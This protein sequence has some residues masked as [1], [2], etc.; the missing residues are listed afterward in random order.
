MLYFTFTNIVDKDN[1]FVEDD[2]FMK[3]VEDLK[4]LVEPTLKNKGF[5][6]PKCQTSLSKKRL[7]DSDNQDNNAKRIKM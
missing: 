7:R 5:F 3:E 6:V 1:D 4:L 2:D